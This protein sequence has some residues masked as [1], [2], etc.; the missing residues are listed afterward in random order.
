MTKSIINKRC[1]R[2]NEV[3]NI[4]NFVKEKY[5]LDGYRKQCKNCCKQRFRKA[6]K[7]YSK[8]EKGRK[9]A[10]KY[11]RIQVARNY[12]HVR[13]RQEIYR[14]IKEGSLIS[15]KKLKCIRCTGEALHYHH[16]KGYNRSNWFD[17]VPVCWP[18]HR[19]IHIKA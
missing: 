17:V 13:A 5:L 16:Y 6:K 15:P 19:I 9:A 7:K 2:C 11:S 12:N 8:S 4:S 3:K 14:K 18:C 10:Y 1:N